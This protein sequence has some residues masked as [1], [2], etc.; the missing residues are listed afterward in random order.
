MDGRG[1]GRT[2][3]KKI[4]KNRSW[5]FN[6]TFKT[7]QAISLAW[8]A[9][10]HTGILNQVID[11]MKHTVFTETFE[12]GLPA[13]HPEANDSSTTPSPPRVGAAS[14]RPIA[15][16]HEEEVGEGP[17]EIGP[18][19]GVQL[20]LQE[21]ELGAGAGAAQGHPST[22]PLTRPQALNRRLSAF[23]FVLFPSQM[24]WI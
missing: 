21:R 14:G 7:H 5:P 6:V 22:L 16:L 24:L 12:W 3:R 13:I 19:L 4:A 1:S 2:C 20:V 18:E 23:L 8:R 10:K 9:T 17:V 11:Q 15:D